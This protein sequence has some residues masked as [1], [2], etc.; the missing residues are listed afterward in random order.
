[1]SVMGIQYKENERTTLNNTDWLTVADHK[2]FEFEVIHNETK[3]V[4][5]LTSAFNYT[6]DVYN[7]DNVN[8]LDNGFTSFIIYN[9]FQISGER[10][11]EYLV[12]VRRIGN[13]WKINKF[14][15]MAALAV[16]TNDYYMSTNTNIIGE[17][18]QELRLH[19]MYKLCLQY[20]ECQKL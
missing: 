9:T 10:V 20:L 4:D 16:N 2:P 8:I 5:S 19:L 15:D 3:N 17:L 7:Q 11:L 1:M 12:N 6:A 18:I 13:N 14:R